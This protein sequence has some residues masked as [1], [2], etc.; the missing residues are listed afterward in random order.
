MNIFVRLCTL[1]HESTNKNSF[2]NSYFSLFCLF[3]ELMYQ[4]HKSLQNSEPR[5]FCSKMTVTGFGVYSKC[6]RND[7]F[8]TFWELHVSITHCFVL[9]IHFSNNMLCFLPLLF[10]SKRKRWA[11]IKDRRHCAALNFTKTFKTKEETSGTSE[12]KMACACCQLSSK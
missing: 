7:Y 6:Q 2:I 5:Q 1:K 8:L 10:M 9:L 3:W 12:N 4:R 11:Q